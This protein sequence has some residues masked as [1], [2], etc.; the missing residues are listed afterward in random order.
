M[1]TE[2]HIIIA[3]TLTKETIERNIESIDQFKKFFNG[4]EIKINN[5]LPDNVCALIDENNKLS[6]NIHIFK[7]VNNELFFAKSIPSI[8]NSNKFNGE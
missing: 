7:I 3:N 6:S 5:H 4:I 1:N 2:Q 8:L